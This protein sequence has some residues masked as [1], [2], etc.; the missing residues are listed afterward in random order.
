LVAD[1]HSSIYWDG[2]NFSSCSGFDAIA[3]NAAGF[4]EFVN[5]NYTTASSNGGRVYS[6]DGAEIV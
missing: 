6:V 3:E 4:I 1:Y 5:H 2:G